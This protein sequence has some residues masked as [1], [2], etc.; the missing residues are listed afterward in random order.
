MGSNHGNLYNEL[1]ILV[2][3]RYRVLHVIM[4]RM[5][6]GVG[7]GDGTVSG[8]GCSGCDDTGGSGVGKEQQRRVEDTGR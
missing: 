3:W 4:N 5:V 8:A 2:R 7:D 6:V 1:I